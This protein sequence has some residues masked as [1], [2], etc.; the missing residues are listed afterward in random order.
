MGAAESDIARTLAAGNAQVVL[1]VVAVAL[2]AACIWLG[3]ALMRSYVDR[4]KDQKE[5]AEQRSEDDKLLAA[6]LR[7]MK[8]AIDL[9]LAAMK[10][11]A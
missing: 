10:G 11:R 5:G 8:S 1:A 9:A 3:K 7:D 2:G 6:A 4:I